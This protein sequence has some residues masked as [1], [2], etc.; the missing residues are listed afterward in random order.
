MQKFVGRYKCTLDSKGRLMIPARFRRIIPADSGEMLVISR[1]QEKC[2]N[3]YPLSEWNEVIGKLSS[4]PPGLKKRNLIR[5]YSD[6]SH[7]LNI[8]KSGRI[9]IPPDFIEMI[10]NSKKVVA[11]GAL[12]Y[13]EIWAEDD[14]DE[15]RKQA[16]D[17]YLEGDWQY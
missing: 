6:K 10:G 17:T 1:G 7:S 3:L 4:L 13:I 14:Y 9:A 15:I 2:L 5:F 8:D 12:T 16:L 11:I